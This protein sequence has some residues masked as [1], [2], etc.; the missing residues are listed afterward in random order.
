MAFCV[1]LWEFGNS[2]SQQRSCDWYLLVR[3][4]PDWASRNEVL[5]VSDR[6]RFCFGVE[7]N[8]SNDFRLPGGW[9]MLLVVMYVEWKTKKFYWESRGM[10]NSYWNLRRNVEIHWV[11]HQ[12][13]LIVTALL[14]IEHRIPWL[15]WCWCKQSYDSNSD[16][17][18]CVSS[19]CFSLT[20]YWI[21]F[22][23]T[24]MFRG[25]LVMG[26]SFN[27]SLF[28]QTFQRVFSKDVKNEF[29]MAFG[30][31]LEIKVSIFWI[32]C[33]I[34]LGNNSDPSIISSMIY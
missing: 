12:W 3:L 14:Q 16:L 30:A 29:R 20:F 9:M 28:K 31:N 11:H 21:L 27:T 25:H 2:F 24:V 18:N 13:Q 22:S 33:R 10:M 5:A 4:G 19:F 26:D 7:Q 23:L 15:W 6:V 1:A 8:S 34:G 32:L 17:L